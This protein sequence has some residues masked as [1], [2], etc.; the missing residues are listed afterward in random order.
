MGLNR[1][2]TGFCRKVS[3]L[4]LVALVILTLSGSDAHI[5]AADK[6]TDNGRVF[7]VLLDRITWQD[8]A[9][10]PAPYLGHLAERGAVGLLVNRT[11]AAETTSPRAYLSIGAGARADAGR[12]A[13]KP[14]NSGTLA[15][16]KRLNSSGTN[17]AR[18]GLLGTTLRRAGVAIAVYGN[19]DARDARGRFYYGREAELI[20]LSETGA[21]AE[22]NTD[23]G[24]LTH[25]ALAR[26]RA[27]Q[28]IIVETGDSRRADDA[29]RST[30]D[31]IGAADI[32]LRRLSNSID[33]NKDLLIVATPSPP[34]GRLGR[35][36]ANLT[37]VI[38]V[39]KG[40]RPGLATSS[41]TR[42]R[43]IVVLADLTASIS[44]YFGLSLGSLSTG[45]P[46]YGTPGHAS[47]ADMAAE[48][49]VYKLSDRVSVPII[50]VYGWVEGVLLIVGCLVVIYGGR[51]RRVFR[52]ALTFSLVW[53]L[54]TSVAIFAAPLLSWSLGSAGATAVTI[55]S[56]ST[57]LA[58]VAWRVGSDDPSR[59]LLIVAGV[60]T[61]F[62]VVDVLIGAPADNRSAL[63]YTLITAGRFYG[64]GNHQVSVLVPAAIISSTLWLERLKGD[65][66]RYLPTLAAFFAFIVF[67][68]GYGGLGANTG[69]IIMSVPAFTWTYLTVSGRLK[70]GGK[71]VWGAFLT[72]GALATLALADAFLGGESSHL[73]LT[74]KEVISGGPSFL[75]RV[76]SRKALLGLAVFRFSYWSYAVI[77]ILGAA[78][79]WYRAAGAK[80]G[81]WLFWRRS[82]ARA[83]VSG[84]IIAAIVGTLAND[85]GI[86]IMAMV[87]GY[88]L[89][90]VLYLEIAERLVDE[91][92]VR[93]EE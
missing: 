78:I 7:L 79:F 58:I 28:L 82:G 52:Q 34:L 62:L 9:K 35:P 77:A 50:V 49:A 69:G 44:H 5:L 15:A 22:S 90:S 18:V 53:A 37:P 61:V 73:G 31:A 8:L 75:A 32:F 71:F 56:L 36:V 60:S 29:G 4:L 43:G 72:V 14:M 39:G 86:A 19:A 92:G 63:G 64:I 47:F 87:L 91:S 23:Y 6:A 38:L 88:L 59:T 12:D 57:I 30:D 45:R 17:G 83:M 1:R 20:G 55:V 10:A 27:G 54:S 24:E 3:A 84:G 46:V 67:L 21:M 25:G 41:S 40:I 2:L 68:I 51:L 65:R 93:S 13:S 11:G 85:S 33:L 26:R 76:V 74:T 48:T 89:L 16:L 66:E 42:R 80:P 70:V 81:G